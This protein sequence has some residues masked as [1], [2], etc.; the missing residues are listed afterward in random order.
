MSG[1][2]ETQ[3]ERTVLAWQ[4]TGLGLLAVAGLVGHRAVHLGRPALLVVAG[5]AA[6]LGIGVLGGLGPARYHRVQQ[7]VATGRPVGDRAAALA[8]T[9]AVVLTALAAAVAVL[10]P[11]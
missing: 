2:V 7:R 5:V 6:L 4:R 11:G 9:A 10:I 3:P 1:P 8:A